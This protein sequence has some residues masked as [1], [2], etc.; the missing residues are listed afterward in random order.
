MKSPR[1]FRVGVVGTDSLRGKEIKN[2]L[3]TKKFPLTHIE[4]YDPDV[5]AEYSKL[6]QFRDE[7]KVIHHLDPEALEGLDLVFL[8]A[9]KKTS[10]TC[11]QL[12][13]KKKFLAIDLSESFSGEPGVPLIVAGVNDDLLTRERFSLIA[14]PHPAT[15]ILSSLLERLGGKFGVAKAVAFILQPVSAFDESGIDELARQSAA[16]LSSASLKKNVFKEQIAFN[17]LSHTEAPGA[18]GFSASEKRVIAEVKKV[19]ASPDLPLSL[20]LIQAPV[21]HTYSI[22]AYLELSRAAEIRD[23]EMA[24]RESPFFKISSPSASRPVSSI[25]VAGKEQIFVGQ[26]KREEAIPNAFWVWTVTDNLTRGSALNALE[27]ARI[28]FALWTQET[29]SS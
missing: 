18:D 28:I 14:N 22:M 7:P 21:F 19:L 23:L 8:A 25:S 27:I 10:R 11:G 1:K 24:F 26:I 6:T 17:I 12:A 16:L 2:I 9:D 3:S 5:E 4:F 20:S 29:S 15:I 13:L